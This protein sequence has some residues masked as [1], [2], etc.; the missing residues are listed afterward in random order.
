MHGGHEGNPIRKGIG[1]VRVVRRNE[2]LYR[3]ATGELDCVLHY[4][5][6]INLDWRCFCNSTNEPKPLRLSTPHSCGNSCSRPRESGCGHPCPLQC[7]PGPCPPCLVTTQ[8]ECHCPKKTILPFRCGID[9]RGKGIRDLSCGKICERTLNCGKHAC[10]KTCHAG[11]CEKCPRTE[12]VKCW[13]GKETK[14]VACGEGKDVECFV[15]GQAPW[16]GRFGCDNLCKRC[17]KFI[18]FWFRF[19]IYTLFFQ[20]IR[21]WKARVPKTV[22]SAFI[23]T[24]DLSPVALEN[25]PLSMQEVYNCAFSIIR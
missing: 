16:I 9:V 21:L 15:E 5:N 11:D 22:S 3:P 25:H 17:A 14:T 4:K 23:K 13:C 2:K 8:L 20:I 6:N 12:E 19:S 24:S 10:E 1:A 18:W 7:H